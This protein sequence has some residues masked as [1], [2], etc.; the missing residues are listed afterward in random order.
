MVHYRYIHL[1]CCV[2]NRQMEDGGKSKALSRTGLL[3]WFARGSRQ[4]FL[5]PSPTI[6]QLLH[7]V[8]PQAD[9]SVVFGPPVFLPVHWW[10]NLLC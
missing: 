1:V 6:F 2:G 10:I 8:L 5:L 9:S 7:M 3:G 4:P